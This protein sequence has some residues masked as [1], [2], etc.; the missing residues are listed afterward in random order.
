MKLITITGETIQ[1]RITKLL[2]NYEKDRKKNGNLRLDYEAY[3]KACIDSMVEKSI[4]VNDD[5]SPMEAR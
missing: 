4:F 1:T 2:K 5:G 3:L